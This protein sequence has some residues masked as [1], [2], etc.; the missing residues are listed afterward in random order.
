MLLLIKNT[1]NDEIQSL[2]I[3]SVQVLQS[4]IEPSEVAITKVVSDRLFV[5]LKKKFQERIIGPHDAI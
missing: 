5:R 3:I 1:A 4:I 2:R